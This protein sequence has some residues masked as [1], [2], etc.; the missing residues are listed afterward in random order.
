VLADLFFGDRKSTELDERRSEK[1]ALFL[2][3][4][5]LRPGG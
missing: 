3:V 2:R 4:S 1:C 5:G